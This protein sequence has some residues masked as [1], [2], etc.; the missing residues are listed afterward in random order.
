MKQET[1]KMT[2]SPITLES[3]VLRNPS[4]IASPLDD[5]LVMLDLEQGMYYGLDDIA[6]LIWN[7][8]DEPVVVRDLCGYLIAQFD[9][10]RHTCETETI[11]FLNEMAQLGLI[12][13]Q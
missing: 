7:Q 11:G 2:T 1:G 8:L 3:T 9:V 5:E 10:D 13:H 12:T 6:T 4:L